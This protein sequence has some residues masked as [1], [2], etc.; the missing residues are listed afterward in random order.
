MI[1]YIKNEPVRFWAAITGIVVAL[2]PVLTLF[3]VIDFTAE[4]VSGVLVL[5]AAVGVAFQFFVV[6]EKVTPVD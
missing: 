1:D 5:L 4:Q 2:F 6:R 3:G